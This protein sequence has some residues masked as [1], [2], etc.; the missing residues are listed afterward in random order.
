VAT[1]TNEIEVRVVRLR[2][3]AR[4]PAY[5][6][7]GAAGLD[8]CASLPDAPVTIAPGERRLVGTG[9]AVAIPPGFE[10]QVRPRSGLAL[11]Y[12]VTVLNSPGTID[13]DYR[14]EI[15][16]VLINH[17]HDPFLVND[18]DRIA[19]LVLATFARA[20]LRE[21]RTLDATERGTA[22]YGSTGR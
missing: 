20:S 22:G 18:G 3:D 9:L 5:Q 6:S 19:Q 8:L 10:A 2:A 21:V 16:I 12:G 14:G 17:G 15:G 11:K 13:A 7:A 1:A 4:L